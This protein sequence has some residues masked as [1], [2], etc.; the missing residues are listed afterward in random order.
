VVSSRGWRLVQ[1]LQGLAPLRAI[2]RRRSAAT[3]RAAA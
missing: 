2:S 3:I 1:K